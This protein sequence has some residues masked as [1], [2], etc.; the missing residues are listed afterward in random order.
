M[1]AGSF[2]G[3]KRPGSGLDH[4][5]PSSAE[6]KERVELFL[7]STSGSSWP[8]L[9]LPLLYFTNTPC[10]WLN[11]VHS[12]NFTFYRRTAVFFACVFKFQKQ[13]FVTFFGRSPN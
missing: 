11:G 1:G 6:V 2:P 5:P 4:P 13:G 7:Y 12:E 8:V 3:V 10:I 9:P